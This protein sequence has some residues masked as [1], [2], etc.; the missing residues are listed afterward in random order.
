MVAEFPLAA[1]EAGA[2]SGQVRAVEAP[3]PGAG[4]P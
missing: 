4:W 3:A 1:S 2:R